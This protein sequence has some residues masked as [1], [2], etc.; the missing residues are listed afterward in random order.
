[1]LSVTAVLLSGR[2]NWRVC[3][4]LAHGRSVGG[5]AWRRTASSR[6]SPTRPVPRWWT[7]PG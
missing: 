4:R 5:P 3:G 1:V 6:F 7:K 2:R